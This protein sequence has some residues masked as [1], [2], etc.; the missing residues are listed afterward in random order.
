ME[1][2]PAGEENY[3]E[4][5]EKKPPKSSRSEKPKQK[6]PNFTPGSLW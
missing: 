4:E 2:T 3:S 6:I 1:G 5:G